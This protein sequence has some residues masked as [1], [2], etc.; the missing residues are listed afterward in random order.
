MSCWQTIQDY[1]L[2]S[3]G[4]G[5][6]GLPKADITLCDLTG[7]GVQDTAIVDLARRRASQPA[8]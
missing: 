2:R 4:I 7:V 5:E 1:G 6:R 8:S 3:L